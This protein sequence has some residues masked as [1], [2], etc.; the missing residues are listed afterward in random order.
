M[1]EKCLRNMSCKCRLCAGEDVSM[2]LN[3]T[4]SISSNIQY[5]NADGDAMDQTLPPPIVRGGVANSPPVPAAKGGVM[6]S[7]P[8]AVAAKR[9]PPPRFAQRRMQMQNSP[10]V[11]DE[12]MEVPEDDVTMMDVQVP[13]APPPVP[14]QVEIAV[15]P[16]P[17]IQTRVP[18]P[19]MPEYLD[20]E[21][22]APTPP[23]MVA[24]APPRFAAPI[25]APSAQTM[26]VIDTP[27]AS[28]GAP[29]MG[30]AGLMA[31][32]AA[33]AASS[34]GEIPPVETLLEKVADKNWK[35]RKVA[36][37]QIK[38]LCEQPGTRGDD[39]SPLL[40]IFSKMCEDANA[41]AMEAGV[42]AVL[43]Y[44][45]HV[46][47]FHK[48][49]VPGVMKRIVDKGFSGRPGTVKL[50]EELVSAFIEAG[51]AEDTVAALIEG[52]KNKKP[53][54]PPAC[55]S[56]ILEGM[57][58]FGPRVVPVQVVKAVLP[59]LCES[60]VNGVRP[61]A[62]NILVEIHRWTGPSLVQDVVS[63]LRQAQQTE[64]EAL[65]K[66]VVAG[67]AQPTKFVR[68][69]KPAAVPGRAAA[70]GGAGGSQ[71]AAG[72]AF[73]PRE[74]AETVNLL[75]KL[76]K[77]EFRTKL[78]QPKWSEKVEALKIVLDLIG[79]VPKLANGEYYELVNT[80]KLL[81]NDSNV[82]IVAKS[83]EVLGALADGLRKNFT[84]NARL[85]YPELMKKLSD[86]KAVIL[87]AVN[88]TLDLFLQHSMG[89]DMM[90]EEIRF[91]VDASKN[92]APQA[93]VQTIGFMA[94]CIEKKLVNLA[95]RA[96]VVDFGTLFVG[97]VDDV[98]PSV[99]KAAVDSFAALVKASEKT[100]QFTSQLMDD[101]SRKNPRSFKAVQ[102]AVGGGGNAS[103]SVSRPS[104][105]GSTGRSAPEIPDTEMSEAPPTTPS[106]APRALA[107]RSASAKPARA[108]PSRLA[109]KAAEPSTPKATAPAAAA[110]KPA[111]SS[112]GGSS[113]A[114]NDFAPFS[115]SVGPEEAEGVLLD[116]QMDSWGAITQ[117]FAS[118]KWMERKEAIERL[119]EFARNNASQM[120]LR[121]IEALTVFMSKQVKDFKDSNINVLKS[122]FQAVVTFAEHTAGKF[123]RGVVCLA[124]PAGVDKL[125]DKKAS[126]TIKSM[127]LQLSEAV[128][129][130][131]VIGCIVHHMSNVKAP[132]VHAEALVVVGE[133][134]SDFGVTVCNPR[135]LVDYAK[136]AFG[137]ESANPKVR[138]NAI[139]LLGTMYSQLGPALLPILNL[140]S[141]KP[142]LAS[143]V[144]AEFKKVGFDPAKAANNAK[145]QIK[146]A[147]ELA[148]GAKADAGA[149]FGRV[150]ISAQITKELVAD[151]KCEDDKTAW[152]KRLAA[153]E[154]IQSICEGAGCAIEFTKPVMEL[155]KLMKAR[156]SDSNA[157]LKVK[158]A[159]VIGVLATSIGPEVGKMSKLIGPSL[160][161]GV[162]DNKKNMQLASVEA[163]H[164]WVRHNNQT[165]ATCL[166]SLLS[167]VAEALANPVGRAELLG[168]LAE[169]L[170]ACDQRL[171]LSCL[172]VPTVQGGLMD[173]SSEAREKAVQ[174]LAFVMKAL[175]K[176]A[177]LT[178]GC[179]DVKPAQMRALKPLIDKA[180]ELAAAFVPSTAQA[181]PAQPQQ[182]V[183]PPAAQAS[184]PSI[185]S[186]TADNDGS[187]L[188]RPGSV[189][190]RTG[191]I[192]RSGLGRTT[193]SFR[194]ESSDGDGGSVQDEIPSTG[195]LKM[196][197]GKAAR[198]SKGQFN[199]WIF[200]P[201]SQSEMNNRKAEIEAEWR[202]Y[203]SPE[204][205]AK[206]FAP[207]LEKG[208]L[209]A[210]SDMMTCI[211]TQQQEVLAALDL[212][213]KWC[214]LRIVDNNVQALAKLLEV[215]VKLFESL[216]GIGYHLD[217]VEAAILLPYL[218]Q[219]S[220]QAKI[221]F[222]LRIRDI[223][224]LVVDVYNMENYVN[225][226]VDCFNTSKNIKS[227]CEC[228]DLIDHIVKS[229]GVTA[230][231]KRAIK[232]IG[233]YVSAHEKEIRES[234]IA[235]LVSVYVQMGDDMDRFFRFTGVTSQQ[236]MDLLSTKIKYL[237][238]GSVVSAPAAP[239]VP[240]QVV[241]QRTGFGYP[242][243]AALSR[244]PPRMPTAS[245]TTPMAGARDFSN[246]PVAASTSAFGFAQNGV[247]PEPEEE[248][249]DVVMMTPAK[250]PQDEASIIHEM[251]MRP[252]DELFTPEKDIVPE[253]SPA[254]V[255]GVEAMKAL[256][257]ITLD[258]SEHGELEFLRKHINE[259][260][261][262]LCDCIHGSMGRGDATR[263][264]S[265]LTLTIA[266]ST[267]RTLFDSDA[268]EDIQRHVVERIILETTGKLLD[269][270]FEGTAPTANI[271]SVEFSTLPADRRRLIYIQKALNSILVMATKKIRAG[272]LYPSIITVLQRIVRN[273]VG[274]YNARDSFNHLMHKDSLDQVVGRLLLKI[275][276]MQA[277]ALNPFEGIDI[278][279]VLMQMHSFFSTLP[280]SDVFAVQIAN[281][282]MQKA[283]QITA[284]S[285]LQT[286]KASFEAAV[287][288]L[289]I[290]SPIRELLSS[291]GI[292]VT[293]SRSFG[294]S[295]FSSYSTSAS[296]S[297]FAVPPVQQFTTTV[298]SVST[299]DS[300]TRRHF[301]AG[302]ATATSRTNGVPSRVG[303]FQ[304]SLADTAD[305]STSRSSFTSARTT[306]ATT[307]V[308]SKTLRERLEKV[309][310]NQQ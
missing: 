297:S 189:P 168:W 224:R 160:L 180:S 196:N 32:P 36:Y 30:D 262:R 216:K 239:A 82:N 243:T 1:E 310:A 18:G 92:K 190:V 219:E 247:H 147:D 107:S 288:D 278:F 235:A 306:S 244:T 60:T 63:N 186:A 198:L 256:Y 251:L 217:D 137:L 283:L 39:V 214:S 182:A 179:R 72:A 134:V 298:P 177:V 282:N 135:M 286:R 263:P 225:Y 90:M 54:V 268:V 174:V 231:G 126:D 305:H 85:M 290:D 40:E 20:A 271:T 52:T 155:M 31:P 123:P 138:S 106:A 65:T 195:M 238:P 149:L 291:M 221:R 280:Q 119:E 215:L 50:C 240:T 206:L 200:D 69:A 188:G 302:G 118:S 205:H 98:D 257:S 261:I 129:P 45:Q 152:K 175:G 128:S 80:L 183:A 96:L 165:S 176:D 173:K 266:L 95:D 89:I 163:L 55:V 254:F 37:E 17:V 237:P 209:A 115:N 66:D 113:S 57:K 150:D 97:A 127:V 121:V 248:D 267:L 259:L 197:N 191:S 229:H 250:E 70:K 299:S 33:A 140:D 294:A 87:N 309:R 211:S 5:D 234:A 281:D 91:G 275:T 15:P 151:L 105:A 265:L 169:H 124:V 117:G 246:I 27:M 232:E 41:S 292:S 103:A 141:W 242:S 26:M 230:V 204:L 258:P 157:N 68:G 158:A 222:R 287:L 148:A 192:A 102:Q 28:A 270:R 62:L 164:K 35:E 255:A 227:R 301:D 11:R 136:G 53:K 162:S 185:V 24:P 16:T 109:G 94:R 61:I 93:R 25:P 273:D 212:I 78:A 154:S 153:M 264:M 139:S 132:L 184:T 284:K 14:M 110:R 156:L 241:P 21:M 79:P 84:Q 159:Q 203:L 51:A 252:L 210:M 285:M 307:E 71:P 178:N 4:K 193:G 88:N 171:D 130:A 114:S 245:S 276:S 269:P 167:S 111:T 143:T 208:M 86:K 19:P 220:G 2:L 226:L 73:D 272:D 108:P 308:S 172:V 293:D 44:A 38:A 99:R 187:H 145:R 300:V 260:A 104:S 233:K 253:H 67:Q 279:G 42:Q 199:K 3:I 277:E 194:A 81:S 64:Y 23:R 223:M 112:G 56:S 144:D 29:M 161:S 34:P 59:A 131:Y 75:E 47:P 10:M 170:K 122:A 274:E 48:G 43:A 166:D 74:F 296:T 101:L 120:S 83:I 116:L 133:C 289:P 295:R 49:V 58:A 100:A 8:I 22:S 236:G 304:S 76:P 77:T 9:A 303:S 213:L 207:T 7:P 218:L 202:P 228:I 125:S 142:A 12:P 181:A 146:D 201:I 13:V 249:E 6:N 46:E